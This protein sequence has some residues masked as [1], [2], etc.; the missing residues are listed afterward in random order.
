MLHSFL[1]SYKTD[2]ENSVRNALFEDLRAKT[3]VSA[4]LIP[5]EKFSTA[6]VITREP[7]IVAGLPWVV[8][9]F[10]QVDPD[11]KLNLLC[12][13]GNEIAENGKLFT[14]EGSAHSILTA[15]RTA[16]NFL[17]T[18]SGVATLT[19]QYVNK[20][21]D[22]HCQLLDTRKTIP[23]LRIAQK[24]AVLCGGGKNHRLGLYDAFLIK[25]NHITACGGISQAV[26]KAKQLAP[27]LKVEVEVETFIELKEAINSGT[28]IIMLDN[29]SREDL[30]EAVS[31][32]NQQPNHK[33]PLLEASG[34]LTL[35]N[36]SDIAKTG[37]NF[38]SI[39]AL[40]KHVR[41]V[42]LSLRIV[43]S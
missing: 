34:N 11:L 8:E 29:F 6:Q 22:T 18:L 2:I 4:A 38:I 31:L 19:S 12:E 7:T 40:T 30:I 28:D 23:G 26:Q 42:D 13:D 10:R 39:G 16:L 1:K 37:V 35:E 15:E 32:V 43:K 27:T 9:T 24:Y 41:A 21:R 20:L 14:V 5:S 17:Q 33:K 36:L 25:E 3:D